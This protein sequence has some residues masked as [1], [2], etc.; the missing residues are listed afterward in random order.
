M[1]NE[2]RNVSEPSHP[3]FPVIG[4]LDGYLKQEF[5]IAKE[6]IPEVHH[7]DPYSDQEIRERSSGIVLLKILYN[8]KYIRYDFIFKDVNSVFELYSGL[9]A[10]NL[11]GKTLQEGMPGIEK[12]WIKAFTQVAVS[13]TPM[14]F[15]TYFK[16]L[17]T[18]FEV[19]AYTPKKGQLT[20]VF[21]NIVEKKQAEGLLRKSEDNFKNLANH[22]KNGFLVLSK[23][24]MFAYANPQCEKISGYSISELSAKPFKSMLIQNEIE[25]VKERFKKRLKGDTIPTRFEIS[26]VKKDGT[27]I[28]TETDASRVTWYGQPAML[29]I[30]RDISDRKKKEE[31]L[32]RKHEDMKQLIDERTKELKETSSELNRKNNEL[33]I[34]KRQLESLNQELLDTNKALSVLARNIDREKNEV[35]KNIAL[36]INQKLIPIIEKYKQESPS[37]VSRDEVSLISA[38]LKD[39]VPEIKNKPGTI[40]ALSTTEFRIANMIKEGFTTPE[41]GNTLFITE[42]T[43]KTHRRNIRKK[44]NLNNSNVNLSTYLQSKLG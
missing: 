22:A 7:Y 21:T 26:F 20:V 32:K 36:T 39:L 43:V 40:F 11:I 6:N 18:D 34:H 16:C 29:C 42:D 3:R 23:N 33:L 44:L 4:G 27:I 10:N 1:S 9:K 35:E 14:A 28:V 30:I 5:P 12:Q 8:K 38:A 37:T 24:G 31:C 17:E 41:I 25:Q 2:L 13:G 15:D 19:F